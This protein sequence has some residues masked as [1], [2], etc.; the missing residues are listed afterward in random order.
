MTGWALD[1]D[2]TAAIAVDVDVDGGLAASIT[3]SPDPTRHRGRLS[4]VRP[5]SRLRGARPDRCR[6]AHRVRVRGINSGPGAADPGLGSSRKVTVGGNPIGHLES[7]TGTS[8]TV[9]LSGWALDPD[10]GASIALRVYLDGR[11]TTTLTA[12]GTRTDVASSYP[13]YG[14]HHGFSAA[15]HEARGRHSVCV[16][17][18]NAGAGAANTG[19]GCR[20]VST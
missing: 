19:L 15:L 13:L 18:M 17:A 14:P 20:A 3:A 2:T 9:H 10:T 6:L 1:P 8:G 11:W 7:L 16:Y 4:R 12:S 5:R